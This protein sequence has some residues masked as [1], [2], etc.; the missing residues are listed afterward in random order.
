MNEAVAPAP[1]SSAQSRWRGSTSLSKK[2]CSR[3]RHRSELS[4]RSN[5]IDDSRPSA[6]NRSYSGNS[7]RG[8]PYRVIW[9]N[10]SGELHEHGIELSGRGIDV[11]RSKHIGLCAGGISEP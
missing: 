11:A 8:Y 4:E 9:H 3:S 2:A 7:S 5:S 1:T 10:H 6:D